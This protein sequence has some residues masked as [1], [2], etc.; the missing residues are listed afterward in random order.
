M[1]DAI[2]Q[3]KALIRSKT[4]LR[5]IEQAD[6]LPIINAVPGDIRVQLWAAR[7]H[8]LRPG[9]TIEGAYMGTR[10]KLKVKHSCGLVSEAEAKNWIKQ[11]PD[12]TWVK[13]C[14]CEGGVRAGSR[15]S[16]EDRTK[17]FKANLKAER[18]GYK[19]ISEYTDSRVAVT[20]KHRCGLELSNKPNVWLH[21]NKSG[22]WSYSCPCERAKKST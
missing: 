6:L 3:A 11:K 4:K 7:F 2:K 17:A 20:L 1:Q 8:A 13:K 18:P 21:R 10:A 15:T 22:N 14:Q 9:Y 16:T 12:G 19:L 5:S